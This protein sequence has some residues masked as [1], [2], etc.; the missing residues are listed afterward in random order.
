MNM[1]QAIQQAAA[2][3]SRGDWREA[4]RLCRLMLEA[5]ADHFDALTL[6]GVIAAQSQRTQEAVAFFGRA[7][8]ADPDNAMAHCNHG[9][10]LRELKRYDEALASCERAIRLRPD[11]ADAHNN[12]GAALQE[13]GRTDEALAS[14]ERAVRLRPDNVQAHSNRGAALRELKRFDEALASFDQA[15]RLAPGHADA[16]F[17]RGNTLLDMK[18]LDAALASYDMVIRL[19]PDYP[20][21]YYQRGLAL[22]GSRQY[23][24]AAQSFARLLELAPGHKLA[25]GALLHARMMCCDWAGLAELHESIKQGFPGRRLSADPFVIQAISE[26]EADLRTCAETYVA[27]KFPAAGASLAGK[28]PRHARVRLGYLSG[29]FREHAISILMTGLWERH[30]KSRFETFA[31]DSGGG[32]G[33]PRRA[34]IEAA[35]DEMIDIRRVSDLEA[36]SLIRAK[37]IDILVNLSGYTGDGRPGIFTYR[38]SPVQVNYLGFPGTMGAEYFDYLIADDTAIP[39]GSRQ[40]YAEKIACLPHSFMANDR[41]RAIADRRFSRAELDLPENTFVFCSFNRLYKITPGTFEGWMRIL[42]QVEGSVLW[43]IEDVRAAEL[44]LRKEAEAQGVSASR[45]IFAKRMPSMEEHLARQRAADLFIDTLPYNAHTTAADALWA[46][47]PVLTCAGRTFPGRVAASLLNAIGL[48]ELIVRTQGEY[49]AM[50]IELATN[51]QRLAQLREKL[52]RSRLTTPLF[53]TGLFAR[54]IEEL[55]MQMYERCQSGLPPDHIH[56]EA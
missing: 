32:D 18:R 28:M 29:E 48:P 43:L 44:N 56:V 52:E 36:A 8:A 55:Y 39:P 21:T 13:L 41:K 26:S 12:R 17:N 20:E 30:D 16:Y 9:N 35:F 19:D 33:S 22:Q 7:A 14:F 4:E 37:E 11:Y 6:S 23:P 40:H 42:K 45:L 47:L 49:E 50:A 24:S 46:G 34:R 15:I 3:Y 38:A 31:F 53:D 51:P 1:Q 27:E 54:H 5:K 25:K 2:A 10:A